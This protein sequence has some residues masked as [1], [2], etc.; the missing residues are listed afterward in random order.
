MF[1]DCDVLLL[2]LYV[3]LIDMKLFYTCVDLSDG[4]MHIHYLPTAALLPTH[5][6][7]EFT[8]IFF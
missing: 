7:T 5:V 3:A 4:S 1:L 6:L 8:Y 2:S